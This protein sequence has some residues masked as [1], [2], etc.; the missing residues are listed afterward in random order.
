M[1]SIIFHCDGLTLWWKPNQTSLPPSRGRKYESGGEKNDLPTGVC[2]M[3]GKWR[4]TTSKAWIASKGIWLLSP[5]KACW[6]AY[7]LTCDAHLI[8]TFGIKNI[9]KFPSLHFVNNLHREPKLGI[10]TSL[11]SC[12]VDIMTQC[13][14][15]WIVS[16]VNLSETVQIKKWVLHKP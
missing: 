10:C 15:A 4:K 14:S 3:E 1:F 11:W 9:T 2:F 8:V 7:R 16:Y 13:L 12:K 5:C 6:R